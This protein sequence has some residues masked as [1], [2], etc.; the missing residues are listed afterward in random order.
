MPAVSESLRPIEPNMNEGPGQSQ[1]QS[2]SVLSRD[3]V[4]WLD[5]VKGHE[6]Q[7]RHTL[8]VIRRRKGV[9]LATVVLIT[10]GTLLLML[11]QT[12][13]YTAS[14]LLMLNT[15]GANVVNVA[16]VIAGLPSDTNAIKSEIDVLESRALAARVIADLGLAGDSEFAPSS[17]GKG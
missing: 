6:N 7:L 4:P 5:L 10:V 11:Q 1:H 14:A 17:S 8:A 2:A 15:R 9:I 12:P 16:A 13:V 3:E